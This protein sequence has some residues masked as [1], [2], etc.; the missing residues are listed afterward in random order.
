MKMG[1]ARS[2]GS[3]WVPPHSQA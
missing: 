1:V 2:A 3:L